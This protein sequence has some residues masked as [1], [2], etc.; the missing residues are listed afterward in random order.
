MVDILSKSTQD[1]AQK[2]EVREAVH[3]LL[4]KGDRPGPGQPLTVP[5]TVDGKQVELT[6]VPATE[7][8][9]KG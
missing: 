6:R 2:P 5:V 7:D 8:E 1:L 3:M 9:S 4:D